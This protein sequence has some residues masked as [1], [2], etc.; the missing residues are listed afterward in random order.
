LF[1]LYVYTVPAQGQPIKAKL[2]PWTALKD[3]QR[4]VHQTIRRLL[5]ISHTPKTLTIPADHINYQAI[6]DLGMTSAEMLTELNGRNAEQAEVKAMRKLI[7]DIQE[8]LG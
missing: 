6:L 2:S 3:D 5:G 1:S 4:V 8:L 7:A